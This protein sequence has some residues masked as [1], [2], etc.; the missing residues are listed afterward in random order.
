MCLAP[1]QVQNAIAYAAQ[2]GLAGR[3]DFKV[4]GGTLGYSGV[5]WGT[6]GYSGVMQGV[7]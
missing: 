1:A 6:L 2:T 3:L 7:L 4:L 5:L